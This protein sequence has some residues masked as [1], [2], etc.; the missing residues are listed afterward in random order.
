MTGKKIPSFFFVLICC[1]ILPSGMLVSHASGGNTGTTVITA[2][3][4]LIAFDI[5]AT[6]IG[7]TFATITWKTNSN[8]DS[9]VE[10]GRTDSY[11][12]IRTNPFMETS[13]TITLKGLSPGTLY[14]VRI[15]SDNRDGY[16]YVSSD[17]PFLTLPTP[18]FIASSGGGGGYASGQNIPSTTPCTDTTPTPTV[19]GNSTTAV[20]VPAL[21][22]VPAQPAAY[23][24]TV[25]GVQWT[26]IFSILFILI[27][28]VAGY[29]F[30]KKHK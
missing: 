2:K 5:A 11:G 16:R 24:K 18:P 27:A 21:T 17:T 29:Y 1:C 6:D 4:S 9:T 7:A 13:H 14:H 19:T 28:S 20:P 12:S 22:I 15:V 30:V 26:I 8:A 25:A 23:P 3:I 10:Y